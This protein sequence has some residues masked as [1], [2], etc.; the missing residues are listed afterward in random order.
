MDVTLSTLLPVTICG[1]ACA[2]G[3]AERCFRHSKTLC[4]KTKKI[5]N[6]QLGQILGKITYDSMS[7]IQSL[8]PPRKYDE[9]CTRAKRRE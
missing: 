9:Y 1:R 6:L 4:P 3:L 7:I 2:L 8:L 5:M